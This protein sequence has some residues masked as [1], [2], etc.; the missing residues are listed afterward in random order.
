MIE[1]EILQALQTAVLAAAAAVDAAYPVKCIGRIFT[2]PTDN[3]DWL[4]IIHIPNNSTDE[5]W[6]DGKTYKGMIRLI[7]H[8]PIDDKGA[9]PGMERMQAICAY[10]T[11]GLRLTIAGQ[12]EVQITDEPNFLGTIEQPPELLFPVSIRYQCFKA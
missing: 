2:P 4:E 7:L 9:Y 1:Q 5:F 10:F 3:T 8:W 12:P 6:S 11:K